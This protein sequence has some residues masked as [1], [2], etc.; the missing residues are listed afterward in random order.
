MIRN[1]AHD[2]EITSLGLLHS[3]SSHW[4]SAANCIRVNFAEV[5]NEAWASVETLSHLGRMSAPYKKHTL[6]SVKAL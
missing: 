1:N 3:S 6:A 4:W 5:K 2:D